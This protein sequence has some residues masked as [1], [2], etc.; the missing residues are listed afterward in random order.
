MAS[1]RQERIR[2]RWCRRRSLSPFHRLIQRIAVINIDE[3]AAAPKTRQRGKR[4]R[5]RWER[6]SRRSAV[7]TI[8]EIVHPWRAASRLSSAMTASSMLRVVFIPK[9]IPHV[10]IWQRVE[11]AQPIES[12]CPQSP[13]RRL[14]APRCRARGPVSYR[15]RYFGG[16]G[17]TLA[18]TSARC[19]PSAPW[20]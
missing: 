18:A 16:G 8:S 3:C 4:P 10:E 2:A 13:A 12:R 6:R 5:F 11:Q 14:P 7:S 9:S 20:R 17:G 1:Q 15:G 19:Q